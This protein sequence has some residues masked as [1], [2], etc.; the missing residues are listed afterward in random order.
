M[1]IINT[2]TIK[3]M[4]AYILLNHGVTFQNIDDSDLELLEDITLLGDGN[5]WYNGEKY[6]AI[7]LEAEYIVEASVVF[8][9]NEK[10]VKKI[11][12][13]IKEAS[14]NLNC[15]IIGD[16]DS[17][18]FGT[19]T[20]YNQKKYILSIL[21]PTF[22][23]ASILKSCLD[24]L[25]ELKRQD[26]EFVV[27]DDCSDDDTVMMLQSYNDPR[28]SF[29]QNTRNGGASYNSHLCFLRANGEYALLI[30][31]ED[32]LFLDEVE[33]L[34]EFLKNNSDISVYIA[35]GIRGENDIKH[36]PDKEYTDGYSAL[37][38]LGYRT[39]YMTGIVFNVSLYQKI[40]GAVSYRNAPDVFNVYSFM[41]AM[42][43]LFFCGRVIT[44]GTM[45]FEETRFTKTT[46]TNNIKSHPDIF[47]FEPNGRQSQILC[48]V[49]NLKELPLNNEQ[50]IFMLFK[51]YYETVKVA[52]RIFEEDQL[53]RY[54]Q[55]I[56][57]HYTTFLEHINGFKRETVINMLYEAT[58]ECAEREEICTR[59]E[60]EYAISSN[61][62]IKAYLRGEQA[63]A[64]YYFPLF[65]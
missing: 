65:S 33:T 39:R 11:N 57:D 5:I 59:K 30:S 64:R 56:P 58:V 24:K 35:G 46:I 20:A 49:K 15:T 26:V 31:D 43:K 22:N 14:D 18:K 17:S 41:Y 13:I 55:L 34:V 28:I 40:I 29:F 10:Y 54:Q 23:R 16:N 45:L 48:G 2:S 19:D 4:A 7:Q 3:K 12:S 50:R 51:I 8:S 63:N 9:E 44:A 47:Y 42:A 38:E 6:S 25:L 1:F 21:I 62:E 36:F 32:D 61:A 37:R 53:D 27:S 52:M 60:F